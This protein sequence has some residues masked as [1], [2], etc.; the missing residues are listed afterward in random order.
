MKASQ[1]ANVDKTLKTDLLAWRV[2][3]AQRRETQTQRHRAYNE[4][5]RLRS[6]AHH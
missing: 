5:P 1:A 6:T 3:N 4:R 2:L